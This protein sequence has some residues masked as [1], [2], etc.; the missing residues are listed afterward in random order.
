MD[1]SHA[2]IFLRH[3]LHEQARLKQIPI[4]KQQQQSNSTSG[5]SLGKG[6]F[7]M[8][9]QNTQVAMLNIEKIKANDIIA[10]CSMDVNVKVASVTL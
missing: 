10:P 5:L 7:R 3:P 1:S 8:S 9:I 4:N 2:F 6:D